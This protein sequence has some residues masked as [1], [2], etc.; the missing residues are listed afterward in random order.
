[1]LECIFLL[2]FVTEG[3][4]LKLEVRVLFHR[5]KLSFFF[6]RDLITVDKRPEIPNFQRLLLDL[7]IFGDEAVY[8]RD[9]DVDGGDIQRKLGNC[10][11]VS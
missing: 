3:N 11:V 1:M 8:C 7:R 2:S 10:Q 9:K 6:F 4:I 5:R